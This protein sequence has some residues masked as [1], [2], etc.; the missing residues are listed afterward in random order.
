MA[1]FQGSASRNVR[2]A[3]SAGRW[4]RK[5]MMSRLVMPNSRSPCKR[6]RDACHYRAESDAALRM[7]LRVEEDLRM[8]DAV[9]VGANQILPGHFEKVVLVAKHI[10]PCVV[11]VEE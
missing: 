2:M 8:H 10:G 9:G 5:H 11:D 7:R 3:S 1:A 4:R 6:A